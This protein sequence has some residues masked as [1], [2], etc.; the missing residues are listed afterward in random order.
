MISIT[1]VV[2]GLIKNS[3]FLEEALARGIVSYSA[4]ARQ[5]RGQIE[6]KL[7]KEVSR[8]AI[9]MAL[10]RITTKLKETKNIPD[11]LIA[12]GEI[13]VRSRLTE[14][15]FLNS[16]T[17]AEKQKMLFAKISKKP[18]VFCD[19]SQ[20]VRETT[21]I[22]SAEIDKDVAKIFTGETMVVKI[23]HL[24]SITIRL[25][26]ESIETPGVYYNVLKLLA[27]EGINVIEVVSTY[28]ELTIVLADKDIDRAFSILSSSQKT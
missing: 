17:I 3:P 28:G 20:G 22:V 13:T 9:V 4:L 19:S 8:G 10:K 5:L 26:K 2:T 7:L 14:F 18:G 6:K 25:P 1:E 16:D 12:L 23:N 11:K 15:S 27:W 24:S 21:L